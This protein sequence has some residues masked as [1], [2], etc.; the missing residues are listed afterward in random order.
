MSKEE[1][2]EEKVIVLTGEECSS[3]DNEDDNSR[4]KKSYKAK[5]SQYPPAP[6]S[7]VISPKSSLS[8]SP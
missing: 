5:V 6:S 8:T 3:S 2:K 4:G 7:H 1:N